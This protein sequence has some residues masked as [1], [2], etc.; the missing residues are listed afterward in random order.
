MKVLV[1]KTYGTALNMAFFHSFL[2]CC[3]FFY[4]WL[5][6]DTRL[7]YHAFGRFVDYPTFFTGWEFFVGSVGHPGGIVEYITE[8]LSQ[9]YYYQ[10][11]GAIMITVVVLLTCLTVGMLVRF[12]GFKSLA[13]FV[14]YTPAI[15]FLAMP[16]KGS[17][18]LFRG[19]R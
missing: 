5:F 1:K 4:I 10:L 11:G 17:G 12:A 16:T 3:F 15:F 13:G 14:G 6:G 19:F 9:L 18:S 7:I 2:F 8:F